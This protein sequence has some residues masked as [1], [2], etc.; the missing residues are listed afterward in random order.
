MKLI[1][2][3]L[4]GLSKQYY[5][6]QFIFGCIF[7]A[8]II[9]VAVNGNKLHADTGKLIGTV[10][11]AVICTLLYPYS[12]FVYESIVGYI[13]GENIF[14]LNA[15]IMMFFKLI[16]MMLCWCF[17]IFI[18]PVGMLYLYFYHTKRERDSASQ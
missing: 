12:R 14:F 15:F 3:T 11:F 10:S 9:A 1:Q 17:S 7:A 2:K 16:T 5:I 4:G 13:M 18:A 8:I 6:R